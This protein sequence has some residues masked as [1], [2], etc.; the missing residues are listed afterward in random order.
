M[1]DLTQTWTFEAR[2]PSLQ[3]G[4]SF[5]S[6]DVA[7]RQR[8]RLPMALDRASTEFATGH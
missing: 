7:F 1:R 5:I 3:T 8:C 2:C 4:H 6:K